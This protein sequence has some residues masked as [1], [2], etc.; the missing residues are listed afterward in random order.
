[1]Y[2]RLDRST[3]SP[4]TV[5]RPTLTQFVVL[6]MLLHML[7][8]ALFGNTSGSGTHRGGVPWGQLDVTMQRLLPEDGS[9]ATRGHSADIDSPAA[10]PARRPLGTHDAPVARALIEERRAARSPQMPDARP[11]DRPEASAEAPRPHLDTAPA[12][13]P[14]PAP[15]STTQLPS[16]EALPHLDPDAPNVVDR[17]VIKPVA[18]TPPPANEPDVAPPAEPAPREVP[19]PPTAAPEPIAA[20]KIARDS[21][22]AAT[23]LPLVEPIVPPAPIEQIAPPK[24]EREPTPPL[25]LKPREALITPSAPAVQIAAPKIERE[26]APPAEFKSSEAPAAPPVSAERNAPA[27]VERESAP[28]TEPLP[29]LPPGTPAAGEDVFKPRRD[30]VPPSPEPGSAPRIDLDAA[31]RRAREIASEGSGPRRLLPFP[32]PPRE[33][34]KSKE[35]IAI[36]KALKPDCRTAYAGLGLAAIVPLLG[37]AIGEGGCKW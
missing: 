37:S 20:P 13:R 2:R 14:Q 31:R 16:T 22:P 30:V 12:T 32:M 3:P 10:A 11:I 27:K 6:S 23:P 36:E 4:A 21:A 25:E 1:M 24:I 29:R 5:D 34:R 18:V 35:A 26:L 19:V 17:P 33:E 15:S 7:A 9:G 28:P 8:I